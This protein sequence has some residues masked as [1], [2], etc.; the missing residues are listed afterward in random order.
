MLYRDELYFEKQAEFTV[1][2]GN[3]SNRMITDNC[4]PLILRRHKTRKDLRII[5]VYG[6]LLLITAFQADKLSFFVND[7]LRI[8]ATFL[9]GA[10][11]Q[12][13]HACGNAEA[14]SAA[15]QTS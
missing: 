1:K 9:I 12:K 7:K 11:E 5:K 10:N 6:G 3:Y 4:S 2:S 14:S 13:I 8:F 15:V